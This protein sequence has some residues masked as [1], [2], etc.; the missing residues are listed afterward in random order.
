MDEYTLM[1]LS[2]RK[3]VK[4]VISKVINAVGNKEL[5]STFNEIAKEMDT[6]AAKLV[7]FS[8]VSCFYPYSRLA[9]GLLNEH[10]WSMGEGRVKSEG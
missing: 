4:N 5:R 2:W 9:P 6:P 1:E 3:G 7:S 10:G 8:I